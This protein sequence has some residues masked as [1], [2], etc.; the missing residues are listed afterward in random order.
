MIKIK[1]KEDIAILREGGRRHGAILRELVKMVA[2]GVSARALEDRTR[3][4]IA[5][6]G[7]DDKPAF[8][9]YTPSGADRPFPAALCLSINN[10]VVHGIPNESDK[11]LKEGDIVTLDLGLIHKGLITDAA[12]TVP[13]G[14]ISGEQHQ[15]QFKGLMGETCIHV[16]LLSCN[17]RSALGTCA[18]LQQNSKWYNV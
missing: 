16:A 14:K 13:V 3:E 1:T 4:L 17:L 8:L 15:Q 12:V 2:P 18:L 5:E 6:G 7:P 11:V 9:N 10:E